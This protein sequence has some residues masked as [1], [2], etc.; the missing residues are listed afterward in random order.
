MLTFTA[1]DLMTPRGRDWSFTV[2]LADYDHDHGRYA[3]DWTVA[4][5]GNILATSGADHAARIRAGC[6]D[7]PDSLASVMATLFSFLSA[8]CEALDYDGSENRDLFPPS[9][10]PLTEAWSSDELAAFGDVVNGESL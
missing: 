8:W 3:Y 2:A 7:Y 1:R 9:L 4:R 5:D 6:K 10:T